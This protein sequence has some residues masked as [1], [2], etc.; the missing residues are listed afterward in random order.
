[1]NR[2]LQRVLNALLIVFCLVT[3][4][5]NSAYAQQSKPIDVAPARIQTADGN[6]VFGPHV[7]VDDLVLVC[8]LQ[9]LAIEN[10]PCNEG[11]AAPI[12][13]G[14]ID[15]YVLVCPIKEV[16]DP[17]H[18]C[19]G[20]GT[21][22]IYSPID[23]LRLVCPLKPLR[24]PDHPCNRDSLLAI[25]FVIPNDYVLTCPIKEVLDPNHPCFDR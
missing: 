11:S 21:A 24:D 1:M 19:F 25:R 8:P 6:P 14:R 7:A 9:P 5:S 22:A 23:D 12:D 16:G 13:R 4:L 10:H 15:D 20:R 3:S 18:P 2:K 17:N